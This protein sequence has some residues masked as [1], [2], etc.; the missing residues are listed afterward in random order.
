VGQSVH[1]FSGSV[2]ELEKSVGFHFTRE[3]EGKVKRSE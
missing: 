2:I 1:S 3:E